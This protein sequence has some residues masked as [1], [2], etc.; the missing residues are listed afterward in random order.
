MDPPG[1]ALPPSKPTSC[2]RATYTP[3]SPAMS[4]TMRLQRARLAG[5]PVPSSPGTG[6][7]AGLALGTMM[8]WA[9]SRAA[10]MGVKECQASSQMRIAARPQDVSKACTLRP[11]ST[12]RSSSNTP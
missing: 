11:D 9:P 4:W 3:C 5:R 8:S 7:R 1:K 2:A 10:S 6:P 12:N